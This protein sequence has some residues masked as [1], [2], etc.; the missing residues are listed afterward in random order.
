MRVYYDFQILTSQKYGGVS[1]Y[2]AELYPRMRAMGVDAR[3]SCLRSVNYYFRDQFK[4][5]EPT[6]N[7]FTLKFVAVINRV[8]ALIKMR[9]C[10]II[11]P[12]YYAPYMLGHYNGKLIVSL[13]D[14]IAEKF[15]TSER[16]IERKRR[17]FY[18]A[19][20]IISVSQNSKNDALDIY[21]DIEPDKISVI[22]QGS[23]IPETE[24]EGDKPI[25]RP[26]VLFVGTR[27]AYKNF[28]RFAEAMRPILEAYPE[29]CVFCVG[30][31]P[32]NDEELGSASKLR[33]RFIHKVLTDDEVRQAYAHAECFVF[34]SYYEGFGLPILEAFS[35]NCPLVCSNVTSLPEIAGDSAE[36]FDPMDKD[37]ITSAILRVIEDEN[38]RKTLRI[39]GRE[40][41]KL[42]SWDKNA[43]ETLA[44]YK[45]VLQG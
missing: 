41:L 8:N 28:K 44:C 16:E 11:H 34:P 36:Y 3:L 33:S 12:T 9:N 35:C 14:M 7:F 15:N 27:N 42:F 20:H 30:S 21:P 40:R 19:D 32:I 31:T 25:G 10:D 24:A 6:K 4:M 2:F 5:H 39:S 13:H 26:Y 1:R 29:L 43:A 22:H 45:R 38:L 37:D 17:M 23:S 18:A